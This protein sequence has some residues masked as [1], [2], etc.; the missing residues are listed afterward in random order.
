[1]QNFRL[2]IEYDGTG[3]AGWQRQDDMPSVQ[4]YLEQAVEKLAGAF[5]EVIGAG[6]TD[7]GVH[8][9][10]Q[11]AHVQ[12]AKPM[13]AYNVMHGINF[14]LLPLTP[15]VVVTEASEASPDFHARF[16][17][18]GRK[19]IYRIINRRARLAVDLYRAWHVPEPLDALR[20]HDGAQLLVGH[21]DFS[22]FRSTRCQAKSAEK[23]LDVLQVSRDDDTIT[24]HAASRS[25]LHHQVRNMAGALRM[26]GNGKWSLADL[27]SSLDA[28]DRT[29][30]AETAPPQGLFLTHILY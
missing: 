30:G 14:H 21:H 10:A 22:T 13:S 1:M 29:K 23:T 3:L 2:T 15:N 5:H 8:A 26:V 16:S 9:L 20:M 27:Q 19:Y 25:F 11:V 17:A 18:I 6:R 7:A 24:M 4:G 12:I 28:R